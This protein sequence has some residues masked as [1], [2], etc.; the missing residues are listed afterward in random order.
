MTS[1]MTTSKTVSYQP[2]LAWFAALAAA[3]VFGVVTLGAFTTSIHAGM[4]FPDWPLSNGSIN[5]DGW[6]TEIDKFAEHSHRLFGMVMGFLAIGTV[7]W[8]Q[9]REPR[10]WLR[11]LGWVALSIVIIQGVLGGKRVLLD[12]LAVPGF[13]M[14]LGEMLRI[15]HGILAHLYA[16]VLFAI[17]ASLSRPW[18]EAP[19]ASSA[20][21][22][23][24][25][26]RKLGIVST[27]LVV[28]QLVVAA[29]MRHNNA[30]LAIPTF[31]LT[32]EGGLLP[33]AWDF[34]VAIHFVHRVM[35]LVLT[36]SLG[37]LVVALLRS[38]AAG[39]G[40]KR[41]ALLIA[42][43]LT[44]Q[45]LLGAVAVW[46]I[47]NPYYTTAH[48]IGGALILATVFTVTWWSHRDIIARRE[49]ATVPL[50]A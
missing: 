35:A 31:P 27:L 2:A 29:V 49:K 11:T 24:S 1:I 3:W 4:A 7:V 20:N 40:L 13:E 37:W 5:P 17:A 28:A 39:R 43:L 38:P 21:N 33:A 47:R 19:V 44:T 34:R 15:P 16:C 41:A 45:I 25:L 30:G 32:P 50:A 22:Q 9:L 23:G 36:G 10:R 6:L 46:T 26:I 14:S 48:V 42:G 12:S 18:I 8:L